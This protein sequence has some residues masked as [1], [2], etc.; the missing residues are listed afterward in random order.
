MV[1]VHISDTMIKF[2]SSILY[3]NAE[4]LIPVD[5]FT[6]DDVAT[7]NIVYQHDDTETTKDKFEITLTDGEHD[8]SQTIPIVIRP[9][10]D[11]T[12]RMTI[13]NG[14]DV[15]LDETKVISS[16]DLNVSNTS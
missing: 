2:L 15:D 5:E 1:C 8:V 11:E 10:D 13:N 12:P 14:I 3:Q 16:N 7:S 4:E 9:V 6:I